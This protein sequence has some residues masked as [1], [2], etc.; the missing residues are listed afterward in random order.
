MLTHP[1]RP[2]TFSSSQSPAWLR[3]MIAYVSPRLILA[4]TFVPEALGA[5]RTFSRHASTVALGPPGT[6]VGT[7]GA[8]VAV[9]CGAAP[10]STLPLTDVKST[11]R[12]APAVAS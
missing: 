3:P 6:A 12:N 10:G 11:F 4:I 2:F 5:S 9:G 7:L 8:G 1:L